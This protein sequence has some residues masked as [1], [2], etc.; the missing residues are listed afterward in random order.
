MMVNLL[1]LLVLL[2]M[3]LLWLLLLLLL[4]LLLLLSL[5]LRL[6]LLLLL[7]PRLVTSASW[8]SIPGTLVSLPGITLAPAFMRLPRHLFLGQHRIIPG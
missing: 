5:W 8:V 6:L 2:L 1:L 4:W 7:Q 3:L